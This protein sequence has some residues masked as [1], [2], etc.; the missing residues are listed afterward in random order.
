L[1]VYAL[2]HDEKSLATLAPSSTRSI[3]GDAAD[4][5]TIQRAGIG[6]AASVTA[7]YQ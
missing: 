6:R 1:V 2:D 3:A 5:E 4:R 7:D